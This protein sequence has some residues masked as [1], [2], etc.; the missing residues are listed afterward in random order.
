MRKTTKL[1]ILLAV[2]ATL[3]LT[4][5]LLS[6]RQARQEAV[7]ESGETILAI[8]PESVTSLAWTNESGSFAFRR[9]GDGWVYEGDEAF[10]VDGEKLTAL[11]EPLEE[12][13]A[14][15]TIEDARDLGQYGLSDPAGSV[16]VGTESGTYTLTL[17]DYSQLDAQRYLSLGDGKVYLVTHD[18][19]EEFDAV[20][21]DLILDDSIPAVAQ[22]EEITFSGA[23]DYTAVYDE[24]GVSVC[25]SDV[26]FSDGRPLD[27]DR[28]TN[29]LDT[30][31]GLTLTDYVTYNATAE[32]TGDYE[33]VTAYLRVGDSRIVYEI[34]QEDY[35]TLAAASYDDLR[36]QKLFT[37][38][39]SQVTELTVTLEG[40]TYTLTHALPESEDEDGKWYYQGEEFDGT[41]LE[42]AVNSLRAT[43][44]TDR[45]ASGREEIRLTAK[46]DREDIPSLSL[47]L[48]RYDGDHCLAALDGETVA[49]VKRSQAVDLIEAIHAVVLTG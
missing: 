16:T 47:T 14:A 39:L 10:P 40:E 21:R 24:D 20:L 6:R 8:D 3:C 37:A 17:G 41:D 13:G 30:L 1:A 42:N 31:S 22:A 9:E 7:R 5:F 2:L 36:H 38:S 27:T 25:G 19:M 35:E 23:A 46:L 15:F 32:E 4:V 43:D 18:P 44:F 33:A 45:T 12:L 11:L 26:Y 49:Y 29:Y 28:V 48:T 34:P